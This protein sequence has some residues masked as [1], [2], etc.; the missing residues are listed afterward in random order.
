VDVLNPDGTMNSLAGADFAGLDRFEARAK[1]VET[2]RQMDLL[3]KEEPYENNVGF[4]ERA[5]VPIEPRLSDQWFLR[6]PKT[7]E[8]RAAVRDHLIRFFPERWEKVYDHW[9][10]NIQDW[11]ISRQLWWGHRIPVWYKDG[12]TRAQIESP[13]EGWTQDPDVL[14]TWFSS[15]LWA[16]ETM[17]TATR[18]KF[19]PTNVLVTGPDIIFFWVAR[20][21]M[22]GLEYTGQVPFRDVFFTGII[23]DKRGDK[24]SKSL[25]NSP[26]PLD[27]IAKYGADGL[28][29]GL[30][31][32]APQGQ[33]IRF[34]EKQI[35]EGRNFAN[36]LWN[37]ARF[38]QMQGPSTADPSLE[39][40]LL[41]PFA[42]DILVKLKECIS[43]IRQSYE[44]YRFND[45]AHALYEFFW[46]EYCDWYVEAV[47]SE[48][49]SQNPMVRGS[50]LMV[51]DYVLSRVLRLLHPFMPHITEE[52]WERMGFTAEGHAPGKKFILFAPEPTPEEIPGLTREEVEAGCRTAAAV[53]EAV[54][55]GRNLRAAY[56]IPSGKRVKF[57]LRA[58]AAWAREWLPVLSQLTQ[59]QEIAF[60]PLYEVP[61]GV[62]G[63]PTPIGELFLPLEGLV[64][65]EGERANSMRISPA[66]GNACQTRHSFPAPRRR[67]WQNIASGNVISW[68]NGISLPRC[69][70][71]W[72]RVRR[73][74]ANPLARRLLPSGMPCAASYLISTKR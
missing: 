20:M 41:S 23:R 12:D 48:I 21:I 62:P 16:Y 52:L 34:D 5:G 26:D 36:K 44:S 1:A 15:W 45:I 42:I 46:S 33:D 56:R 65:P 63:L 31:R 74:R 11:C 58:Q 70:R 43:R 22:A 4:S 10:E 35:E 7:R 71:R 55:V 19:Y 13:G 38:R 50:A 29:F 47:K 67:W 17:D 27:L 68:R 49:Q 2:L 28:R 30:L 14:D 25:G 18:N 64:D 61:K 37:A 54:R 59:A 8:A 3:V 51:M 60:D 53:Y 39:G 40:L 73:C 72:D 57:V 69:W 66:P 9:L 24:M 32:I 6:Y